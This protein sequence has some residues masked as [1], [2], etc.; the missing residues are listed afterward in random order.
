MST[1]LRVVLLALAVM[2]ALASCRGQSPE[3]TP[4]PPETVQ[5]PVSG[6]PAREAS[7]VLNPEDSGRLMLS[8]G[9]E[10][11]FAERSVASRAVVTWR[12]LDEPPEASVPLSVI[13]EA[14]E[15]TTEGDSLSGIASL[16]LPLPQDVTP[17]RY[18][19]AAYRWSEKGWERIGG[20]IEP[21]GGA[22]V[23]GTRRPG[24]FALLGSWNGASVNLAL[25]R[26]EAVPGAAT[27]PFKVAGEYQYAAAPVL[28]GDLIPARLLLKQDTS[29][30]AGQI[31]GNLSL[32]ATVAEAQ[33]FF[34]PDSG[35]ERGRIQFAHQ[36]EVAPGELQIA[37]GEATRFYAVLTA[38]DGPAP[39]RNTS[40]GLAYVQ[41]LP[42]RA[43]GD[44]IV[45]P[46]LAVER[47][48]PLRW[49]LRL[50]GRTLALPPADETRLPLADYLAQGG[51][52]EYRIVLEVESGGVWEPVSNEVTVV[53]AVP[54]TPTPAVIAEL[55][56]EG[57]E[58][59]LPVAGNA[60]PG[61][62]P[63][64]PTRRPTP[65]GGVEQ[66][67]AAATPTVQVTVP[68]LPTPTPTRPA[69]ASTFWADRYNVAPG[70]CTGLH[71][72][73]QNVLEV[74]LDG[75]P[76]TGR[77]DRTVCPAQTTNYGLRVRSASGVQ[78]RTVTVAVVQP[79]ESAFDFSAD[80]TLINAGT[81]TTLRWRV[82][83]V[84]GVFLN[85]QGVAGESALEICPTQTTA[86]TLRVED[87]QGHVTSRQLTVTVLDALEPQ[88]RLWAERY[89]LAPGSCT[90]VHWEVSNVQAV[91]FGAMG[92][93][94]A[95]ASGTGMQQVC[96]E[97][98]ETYQLRVKTRDNQEKVY[99]ISV[100]IGAPLSEGEIVVQGLVNQVQQAA[101]TDPLLGGDQ[102]GWSVTLDGIN[103]IDGGPA[104]GISNLTVSVPQSLITS[105]S[106]SPVDWP[107]EPGQ[108]VELRARCQ[109][110]LCALVGPSAYL[111]LRSR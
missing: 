99:E 10:I 12:R 8:D 68:P 31:T 36:F 83:N 76:V 108:L 7:G 109:A 72:D 101:D 64:T 61:I 23:V 35:T 32:D 96:P 81:C 19:L 53:L 50:G 67:E 86:Y 65:A 70:E 100:G 41:N 94:P 39:T 98:M 84:A 63:P 37:P 57:S 2:L 51:L 4:T 29:G 54:G 15:L 93:E 60:T 1:R 102:P 46:A 40:N 38:E 28:A 85:D 73:V 91:Y 25:I 111:W 47:G 88:V 92:E 77:E 16:R 80:S 110:N 106:E 49:H 105:H 3:A 21:D 44:A 48:Q 11:A 20:R 71:W 6:L 22:V 58:V 18:D 42:I 107:L 74:Y 89:W 78:D 97:G 30:G 66:V 79:G 82:T 26:P 9:A 34:K 69:W 90:V 55:G 27:V 13:G 75:A 87:I 17:D 24:V 45:R 103:R 14:Y 59:A 5:T 56:P 52:G 104:T 95:G 62:S 43:V 33:L